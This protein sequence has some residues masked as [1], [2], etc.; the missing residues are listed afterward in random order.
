MYTGAFYLLGAIATF[1][2]VLT[3]TNATTE[4]NAAQSLSQQLQST[5]SQSQQL[6]SLKTR[7]IS[8]SC[9]PRTSS[10]KKIT[11]HLS[12]MELHWT[13]YNRRGQLCELAWLNIANA[14]LW[15]NY[16]ASL[17]LPPPPPEEEEEQE[18][19]EEEPEHLPLP[20]EGP[21]NKTG[22][23][24]QEVSYWWLYCMNGCCCFRAYF[25]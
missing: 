10:R 5:Q 18:A 2:V 4:S 21:A 3:P 23:N 16:S 9:R 25:G 20:P 17:F 24:D 1:D 11:Y 14:T 7:A 12:G 19:E 6:Q 15:L 22:M 8:P 13:D